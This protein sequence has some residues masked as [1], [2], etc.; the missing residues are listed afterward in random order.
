MDH[1]KI[2]Q[3]AIAGKRW[4]WH[5]LLLTALPRHGKQHIACCWAQGRAKKRSLMR[6]AKEASQKQQGC[7]RIS[8]SGQGQWLTKQPGTMHILPLHCHPPEQQWGHSNN[9]AFF[10]SDQVNY[11]HTQDSGGTMEVGG[12]CLHMH[13]YARTHTHTLSNTERFLFMNT[14]GCAMQYTTASFKWLVPPFKR[15][16]TVAMHNS[17]QKRNKQATEK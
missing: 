11:E 5:G 1:N 16:S 9:V 14:D 4:H 15:V 8:S 6:Y 13:A 3:K 7:T 10:C 12:Y 17:P 2:R